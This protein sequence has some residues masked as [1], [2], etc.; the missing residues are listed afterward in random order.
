MKV[1]EGKRSPP[2]TNMEEVNLN[3]RSGINEV[4]M[5]DISM[6]TINTKS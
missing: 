5:T 6:D 2:G 3:N 4:R 1:L